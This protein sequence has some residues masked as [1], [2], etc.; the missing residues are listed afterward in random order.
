MAWCVL[1]KEKKERDAEK[2]RIHRKRLAKRLKDK[3]AKAAKAAEGSVV[4]FE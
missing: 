2:E 3:A 4:T 1:K